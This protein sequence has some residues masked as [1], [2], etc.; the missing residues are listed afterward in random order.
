MGGK[1]ENPYPYLAQALINNYILERRTLP[2]PSL[3]H[4]ICH[5]IAIF[6]RYLLW[7]WASYRKNE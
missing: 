3:C 5:N 6:Y 1:K 2:P 7:E 4:T